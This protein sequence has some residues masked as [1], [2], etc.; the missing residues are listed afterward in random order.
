MAEISPVQI[1]ALGALVANQDQGKIARPL[2]PLVNT[3]F[4]TYDYPPMVVSIFNAI[5]VAHSGIYPSGPAHDICPQLTAAAVQHAV[6]KLLG[7]TVVALVADMNLFPWYGDLYTLCPTKYLV[8]GVVSWKIVLAL[9]ALW[10]S[11]ICFGAIWLLVFAGPRWAPTLNGF[12]MFKFGAQYGEEVS[13]FRTAEPGGCMD[14]LDHVLGMV[15]LLLGNGLGEDVRLGFI[16]LS[17]C[18]ITRQTIREMKAGR[19]KLTMDRVK[20]AKTRRYL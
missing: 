20:A 6:Y 12:E 11:M 7:E 14:V 17:E 1:I 5:N 3:N 16:G 4:R 9:L 18:E 13:Q 2:K 15:G 8:T 10:A 19:V